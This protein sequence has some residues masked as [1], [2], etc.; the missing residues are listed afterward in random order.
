MSSTKPER[1]RQ[2]G[3]AGTCKPV[4]EPTFV[5]NVLDDRSSAFRGI[6][7]RWSMAP[8][9]DRK[10][11]LRAFGPVPKH[12]PRF[13]EPDLHRASTPSRPDLGSLGGD[14][15]F[16]PVPRHRPSFP[17]ADLPAR[18]SR[19]SRISAVWAG[20]GR[21]LRTRTHLGS[22]A[23]ADIPRACRARIRGLDTEG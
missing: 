1:S 18:R 13:P 19:A 6:C 11:G 12:R 3:R 7:A 16:G 20:S 21:S 15:T 5:P 14:R 23:D 22:T 9:T 10:G 4:L 8:S 2:I 17:K